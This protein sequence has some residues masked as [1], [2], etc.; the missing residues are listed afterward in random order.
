[1]TSWSKS[2]KS[3]VEVLLFDLSHLNACEVGGPASNAR[4]HQRY[5]L[6]QQREGAARHLQRRDADAVAIELELVD[7]AE[8]GVELVLH[9]DIFTQYF[10][11]NMDGGARQ[12]DLGDGRIG[13]RISQ[14]QKADRK[15]EE[16]PRPLPEAGRSDIT[17]MSSRSFR[18][19]YCKT[20]RTTGC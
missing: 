10:A 6:P 4:V 13:D 17:L 12:V 7:A 5:A 18:P 15:G 3:E 1:M 20:S 16:E 2:A 14:F 8:G 11:F 19:R 9:A